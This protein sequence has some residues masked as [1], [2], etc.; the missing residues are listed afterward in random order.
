MTLSAD[1]DAASSWQ[2]LGRWIGQGLGTL[3]VLERED[4]GR[5]RLLMRVEPRT[6]IEFDVLSVV[7][8][9]RRRSGALRLA[10]CQWTKIIPLEGAEHGGGR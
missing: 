2:G 3:K 5:I 8:C 7:H 1:L 4:T 6:R 10:Y 9:P